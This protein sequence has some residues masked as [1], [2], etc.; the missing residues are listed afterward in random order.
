MKNS[1]EGEMG[2]FQAAPAWKK[3]SDDEDRTILH[4]LKNAFGNYESETIPPYPQGRPELHLR[5]KKYFQ[6]TYL[7]PESLLFH[8]SNA[9]KHR[10]QGLSTE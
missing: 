7:L 2:A 4:Q 3:A 1:A 9:G 6:G 8:K 5:N 10:R